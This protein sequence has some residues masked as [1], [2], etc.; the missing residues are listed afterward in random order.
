MHGNAGG[1]G[2]V[3]TSFQRF[4]TCSSE[5]GPH[6]TGPFETLTSPFEAMFPSELSL[7]SSISLRSI[8]AWIASLRSISA[9]SLVARDAA[10]RRFLLIFGTRWCSMELLLAIM[11]QKKT[12]SEQ[13]ALGSPS[14]LRISK[15]TAMVSAT[16][17]LKLFEPKWIRHYLFVSLFW[18]QVILI[19]INNDWDMQWKNLDKQ[20]KT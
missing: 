9:W 15:A 1:G 12:V 2:G 3:G 5:Q 10:L 18:V 8:F 7:L 19:H 14:N 20:W 13:S 11:P 4:F 6:V 16:T 17:T